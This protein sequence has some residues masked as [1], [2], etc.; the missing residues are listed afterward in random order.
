MKTVTRDIKFLRGYI[1]CKFFE[2]K[3]M[4]PIT[5][6]CKNGN[7]TC[8]G[9]CCTAM[10]IFLTQSEALKIAEYIHKNSI[11]QENREWEKEFPETCDENTKNKKIRIDL[12][13]CFYNRKEKKC[14]IYEVCPSIC[15]AF[16]CNQKQQEIEQNKVMASRYTYYNKLNDKL[17]YN[18]QNITNF[19]ML[20]YKDMMPLQLWFEKAIGIENILEWLIFKQFLSTDYITF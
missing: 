20:F 5:S 7:C 8:C 13:C 17:P 1:N 18:A 15:R 2:L 4:K 10:P 14:N 16:K 19:D 6:Y 12:A 9:E 3:K 11:I